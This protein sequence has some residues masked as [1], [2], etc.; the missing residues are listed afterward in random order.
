[1]PPMP[2]SSTL[3]STQPDAI[4][5]SI[6]RRR[7]EG[8]DLSDLQPHFGNKPANPSS[9]SSG[10]SLSHSAATAGYP[11]SSLFNMHSTATIIPQ[12][13]SHRLPDSGPPFK[14]ARRED[15][16]SPC[17]VGHEGMPHPAL[18]P[19][20]PKLKFTPEDDLL[21]IELKE[22]KNLTWKQISDFFPGRSSGTLQ[23]RYC[24]KL[25]AK[26]T[27]WTDEMVSHGALSKACCE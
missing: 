26:S 15:A 1:M 27:K 9:S 5:P 8:L 25:K 23:V 12:Y 13:H 14:I 3:S 6:K 18:R 16:G 11:I 2:H 21:L 4:T 24:T 17:V 19:K 22:G 20:G 10:H 7:A